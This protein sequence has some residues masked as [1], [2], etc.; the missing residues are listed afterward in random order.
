[1]PNNNTAIMRL[2]DYSFV[3]WPVGCGD[4][5]T[6]TLGND[7]TLQ[8]DINNCELADEWN[9]RIPVVD[10]LVARLPKRN[11]RP[12]LACFALTHPDLDHVRG[13]KELLK[14]VQIGEIWFTPRVFWEFKQDL[15]DDAKAFCNEASRRV[16]QTIAAA[17][18]P[19]SGHRVRVIGYSEL[20]QQQDYK[21]FPAEFLTI[22]GNAVTKIDGTD[23]GQRFSAFIHAPFKDDAA[24]ERN[25]TS[26]AMQIT[27]SN[28][29]SVGRGLFFGDLSYP[30]IRRI[31]DETHRHNNDARLIWDVHLC[32]HHCSKKVMYVPDEDGV[33]RLQ[34]DILDE[35]NMAQATGGYIVS[36]S[37]AF[38]LSNSP[39]D[40][41]PHIKARRRYE[42]IAD[43][44]FLCTCEYS[45][46]TDVRP[47]IF[48]L[49]AY[50]LTLIDAPYSLSESTRSR[51]AEAVAA[52]RGSAAPPAQKVGFGSAR[53]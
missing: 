25:E 28:G 51:L 14:R 41:P 20:L 9:E 19:S 34:Q 16:K 1:V 21:G 12:Y 10:E 46:E 7:L 31:F 6:I 42:E 36:S 8:I 48:T 40:N 4:C 39:G 26:L 37:P 33:E 47:I 11:G 3:F 38:P 13:F 27:V 2:P 50:G 17:G 35:L 43:G 52:A 24:G 53:D 22:P 45:T 18:D 29:L 44:G 32:A 15:S 23:L 49:G 5:T 30:T